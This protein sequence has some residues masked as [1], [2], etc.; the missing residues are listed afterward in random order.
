MGLRSNSWLCVVLLNRRY[1]RIPVGGWL[2]IHDQGGNGD[3]MSRLQS[4]CLSGRARALLFGVMAVAL[5]ACAGASVAPE[6]NRLPMSPNRPTTVYVYPFAVNSQD[7][8]LNQGFFQKTYR[9]F[10]SS[11]AEQ[12]QSQQQL[13]QATAQDLAAAIVSEL[14]DLGFTA[15]QVQRGQQVTG[16]NVLIVDG[17]FTAINEGNKL[18]R[19]VIGL[20]AGQSTLN[21]QVQVYQMVAGNAQQIMNFSTSANSGSMPGAAFTAPAGAAVGGAAAAASLGANLAA[22]ATKN[23]TSG[24]G[25]LAKKTADQAVAYMSQYFG[26]QAWIP[27]NMVKAAKQGSTSNF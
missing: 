22:G 9:S 8:T 21:T 20:G 16:D 12:D 3:D 10:T 2:E 24:M 23:Y 17:Q 7:V 11:E 13:A 25:Y 15:A 4:V 6:A 14:Q 27:Q 26:V 18:R 1:R 19:M 5:T